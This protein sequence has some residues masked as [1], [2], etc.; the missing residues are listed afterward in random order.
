LRLRKIFNKTTEKIPLPPKKDGTDTP[1]ARGNNNG[2]NG[3]KDYPTVPRATHAHESLKAGE[4]CPECGKGKLS[5]Y[6]PGITG[7][8]PL[9]AVV[10]E[11]EKF[12][13]NA[14]LVI[15]EAN[16]AGKNKPKY[17]EGAHA[18]IAV[19]K[20]GASVPFYRLEK[21]QKTNASFYSVGS[22]GEFRKPS[23]SH[24]AITLKKSIGRK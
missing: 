20:Y 5:R 16:F 4:T 17:D 3:Q 11:T 8:A 9:K 14:C 13:C 19:L 12:R 10:H 21:I 1:H 18:I 22:D 6:E 7:S 15:F 2:K 23:L 24:L